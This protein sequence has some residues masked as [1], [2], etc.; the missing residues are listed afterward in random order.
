[1]FNLPAANL[2]PS[3]FGW[4]IVWLLVIVLLWWLGAILYF[5]V[6]RPQRIAKHGK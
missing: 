4:L 5:V 2:P 3:L 6:R 1:M